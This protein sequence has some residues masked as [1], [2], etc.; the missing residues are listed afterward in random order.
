MDYWL[1]PESLIID[2]HVIIQFENLHFFSI[3]YIFVRYFCSLNMNL[4]L[5]SSQSCIPLDCL[6][7]AFLRSE[8]G[9]R[10]C[11]VIHMFVEKSNSSRKNFIMFASNL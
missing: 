3:I 9:P 2:S 6:R 1:F 10:L 4:S 7:C 8:I 5:Y 11:Q